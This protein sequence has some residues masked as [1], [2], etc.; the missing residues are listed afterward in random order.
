MFSSSEMFQEPAHVSSSWRSGV[1]IVL[2]VLR[3]F[4][5]GLRP[6]VLW[7]ILR[8]HVPKQSILFE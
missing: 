7:L 1:I 6:W 8:A 5:R 3:L 4:L 2:S